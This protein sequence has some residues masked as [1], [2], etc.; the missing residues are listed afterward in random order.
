MKKVRAISAYAREIRGYF[1]FNN[2]TVT[3]NYSDYVMGIAMRNVK[4]YF[5]WIRVQDVSS[6]EIM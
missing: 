3:V 2:Y 6:E 4:S 5:N 1:V